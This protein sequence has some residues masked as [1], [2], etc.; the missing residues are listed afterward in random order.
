MEIKNCTVIY[1]GC[2][3]NVPGKDIEE[4]LV[5][6]NDYDRNTRK[7]VLKSVDESL[8][9]LLPKAKSNTLTPKERKWFCDDVGIWFTEQVRTDKHEQ[10]Y[11]GQKN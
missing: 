6:L 1:E 7:R 10:Y 2:I 11:Q 3:V 4:C 9:K 5:V 8:K